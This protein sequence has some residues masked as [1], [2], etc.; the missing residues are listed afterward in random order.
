[1]I[2]INTLR[3]GDTVS[4]VYFCKQKNT[5]INKAGKNYYSLILQDKTGTI[6]G[7]IWELNGAIE[8]FEAGDFIC[9]D[10]RVTMFNNAHQLNI[11]RV[12][13]AWDGEYSMEDYMPASIWLNIFF[14][15][16]RISL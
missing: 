1:M 14:S 6:D 15:F 5:A 4:E 8:H 12:R 2:F 11:T 16:F 7:K 10:A 3:E 13:R 9:I